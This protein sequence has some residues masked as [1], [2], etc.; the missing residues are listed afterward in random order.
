MLLVAW[1]GADEYENSLGTRASTVQPTATPLFTYEPRDHG[2][3]DYLAR[4]C[5]KIYANE[6]QEE[7]FQNEYDRYVGIGRVKPPTGK[8]FFP[9]SGGKPTKANT[10]SSL[11]WPTTYYLYLQCLPRMNAYLVGPRTC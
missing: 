5:E 4:F 7:D 8:R 11:D 9:F 10:L 2:C 6:Q 1:C 3:P